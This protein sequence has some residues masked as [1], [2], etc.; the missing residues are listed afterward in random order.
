MNSK[1]IDGEIR[2]YKKNPKAY[3][4]MIKKFLKRFPRLRRES[5]KEAKRLTKGN[6][7]V[8]VGDIVRFRDE[9]RRPVSQRVKVKWIMKAKPNKEFVDFN[10]IT[11]KGTFH[12]Q[13]LQGTKA[14]KLYYSKERRESVNEAMNPSAVRKMRAEFERTGELPPHLKKFVKDVNILKKK[15]KVKNIVVPGLEWMSDMKE[16]SVNE[17]MTSSQGKEVLRQLGGGRFIAMT[18]AKNFGTDGKSL[19]FKIGRNSKGVNFVRI[20]LTSMDLYDI[21]FL[22]VRAGKIKIKSKAKRVYADQLG[23]MFKKNTGMNVRL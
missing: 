2:Q 19:T 18:G 10:Y 3:K 8:K 17:G 22:Q 13:H 4:R 23:K 15:H 9:H 20:K 7:G 21:E 5:V 1:H 6:R 16:Q 14:W 12:D 11:N